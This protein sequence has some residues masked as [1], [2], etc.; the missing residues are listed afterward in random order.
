MRVIWLNQSYWLKPG[1]QV[2]VAVHNA[3][4]FL[5]HADSVHLLIGRPPHA[6]PPDLQSDLASFYGLKPAGSFH[7]EA[8]PPAPR[9]LKWIH[10]P[11]IRRLEALL[12][13]RRPTLVLTRETSLLS[14]LARLRRRHSGVRVLYEAHDL[15][16]D[17][18]HR[19]A[20]LLRDRL[21]GRCERL[22]LPRLDG[23]ICLTPDQQ[24]RY[25][26]LLPQVPSLV[27]PLGVCPQPTDSIAARFRLRR[28]VYIGHLHEDKGAGLFSDLAHELSGRNIALSLIG[29]SPDQARRLQ[30][31]IACRGPVPGLEVQPFLAPA[32]L[33]RLLHD[34]VSLGLAPY[35]ATDH[36]RFLA[37]PV[38][39][40]DYLAHGLPMA[41]SDLESIRL[42]AGDAA[43]LLPAGAPA[44]RWAE[45]AAELLSDSDRYETLSVRLS[46]RAEE[47]TWE[48]RAKKILAWIN[49]R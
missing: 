3:A 41:A 37:N 12:Q 27:A 43:R 44:S 36:N 29:G 32:A 33:H 34:Q 4:A 35:A 31:S 24:A 20:P 39:V 6:P 5:P 1:P 9:L 48:K 17:P 46:R 15:Y 23:L 47:Q 49:S 42:L 21:R 19:P 28:A 18:R 30:Q 2:Y 8:L 10:R 40:L 26:R 13:D 45:S 14:A 11:M 38:K 7:I 16:A 25:A 22:S